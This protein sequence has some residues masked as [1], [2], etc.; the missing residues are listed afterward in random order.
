M[1]HPIPEE[2]DRPYRAAWRSRDQREQSR[3]ARR[4]AEGLGELWDPPLERDGSE[5]NRALHEVIDLP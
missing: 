5:L 2:T 1:A 4:L 3:R